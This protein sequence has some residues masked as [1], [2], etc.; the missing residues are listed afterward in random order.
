MSV[1]LFGV[2][3]QQALAQTK[4]TNQYLEHNSVK[5]FRGKAENVVLGSYGEKKNP[6]GS[7]A[8]LAIQNNIRAEHLNNRVRVLSPVE[9]TWNNTTK[10][11][12]EANGSLRVY[13]LNLS[14]ARNMTFEQARSGRLKLVKLFI[15][16]GALQTMLNRDA[17]AARNYLAREGTDARIVSEVWVVMEAELAEHFDTSSSIRV[18]VSRGQQAALEITAS[19]GIHRSQSI[20]LSAGNVF[21]YL[22]HK[23]KSWNRDKTEIENM[24]DDQSGLN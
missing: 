10:A 3:A 5:Y 16:E 24:E 20:T 2:S 17:L 19:G 4:I 14:A 12:V 9:I 15:N 23:V 18:E 11:E 8:Y 7:A 1:M 13:G 21:A 22:L 6:I